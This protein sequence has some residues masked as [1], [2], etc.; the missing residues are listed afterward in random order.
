MV[1]LG[2]TGPPAVIRRYDGGQTIHEEG[3]TAAA[4][5]YV[6]TEGLAKLSLGYPA[7]K[8]VPV[9]LVGVWEA[10]GLATLLDLEL[11]RRQE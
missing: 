1:L 2:E 3:E 8:E 4:A 11:E 10:L 5:L 9:R 6:L 7:G